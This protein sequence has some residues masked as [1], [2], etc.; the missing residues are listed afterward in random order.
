MIYKIVAVL[1]FCMAAHVSV[2]HAQVSD[3]GS[4]V[5][6]SAAAPVSIDQLNPESDIGAVVS[7]VA[8]A[9]QSKNWRMLGALV[10]MLLTY[11]S[12]KFLA[13]RV[14]FFASDRGGAVLALAMGVL[15]SFAHLLAAG[16]SMGFGVVVDGL[17]AGFMAAGGWSV[18]KK[19]VSTPTAAMTSAP[20]PG[21]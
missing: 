18:A 9:V 8:G 19:L 16:G 2:S 10:I 15:A 12:R 3:G 21:K 4:V 6:A 5:P 1:M 13:P 7:A 20:V 17:V 14:K 11:A